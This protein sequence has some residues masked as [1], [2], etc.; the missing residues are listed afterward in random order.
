MDF[1]KLYRCV[2]EDGRCSRLSEAE[3]YDYAE[4]AAYG[5]EVIDTRLEH[6][7]ANTVI[8]CGPHLPFCFATR[9]APGE[10]GVLVHPEAVIGRSLTDAA[11]DE[12][13]DWSGVA[14]ETDEQGIIVG[15]TRAQGATTA[16]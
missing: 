7:L 1:H 11:Q 12:L 6:P 14:A 16:H 8:R 15:V 9:F 2:Y 10:I 5:I 3:T 13:L 4:C